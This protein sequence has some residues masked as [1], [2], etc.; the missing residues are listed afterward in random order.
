VI[1]RPKEAYNHKT[2]GFSMKKSTFFIAGMAVVLLA[3]GF[4]TG[5]A[6]TGG[7]VDDGGFG[8][9]RLTTLFNGDR[10]FAIAEGGGTFVAVGQGKIAYS[11]DAKTWKNADV[12]E[13]FG[14]NYLDSGVVYGNGLFITGSQKGVVASSPNGADWTA[15]NV[16]AIFGDARIRRVVWADGKFYILGNNGKLAIS[17]DGTTWTANDLGGFFSDKPP[18]GLAIG[19]G[20]YVVVGNNGTIIYS[21]DGTSWTATDSALGNDQIN[22]VVWNGERFVIVAGQ[23]TMAYSPDGVTWTATDSTFGDSRLINIAF[24]AGKFLAVGYYGKMAYSADGVTWAAIQQGIGKGKTQWPKTDEGTP[25]EI[26]GAAYIG[27]RF[28]ACGRNGRIVYSAPQE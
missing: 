6:T 1:D 22:Q 2:G 16:G 10:V 12:R 18:R 27:G 23:G 9:T 5:C 15:V 4:V 7:A 21:T 26:L 3:I 20:K 25:E 13:L 28:Y 11:A 8:F 17:S 14:G 19:G 24:G